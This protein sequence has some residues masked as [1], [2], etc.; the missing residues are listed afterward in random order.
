[1]HLATCP[2]Q[3]CRSRQ[4]HEVEGVLRHNLNPQQGL[5]R[6]RAKD[7]KIVVEI[8]KARLQ[9]NRLDPGCRGAFDKVLRS[10][11]RSIVVADDVK[12]GKRRWHGEGGKVITDSA[13]SIGMKGSAFAHGQHGFDSFAAMMP[14]A[15][16][17]LA[18]RTGYR[19]R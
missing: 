9:D 3:P 4:H 15:C 11:S 19:C 16:R 10:A 6:L 2:H 12:T 8:S 13:A 7:T 1:M 14:G 5:Q 17:P 18:C